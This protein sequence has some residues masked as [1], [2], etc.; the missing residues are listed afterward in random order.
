VHR[1]REEVKAYIGPTSGF[2]SYLKGRNTFRVYL[3]PDLSLS[4]I[5]VP[6]FCTLCNINKCC[7][8]IT[9]ETDK[10]IKDTVSLNLRHIRNDAPLRIDLNKDNSKRLDYHK[11]IDITLDIKKEFDN[12]IG[13]NA[14]VSHNGLV[15]ILEI[16]GIKETYYNN[17]LYNPK[18]SVIT[19]TYNTNL[20]LF[21]ETVGSVLNQSYG[22][23]E[24]C[25]I[26]DK[27]TSVELKE[28]IGGL[29]SI[30]K[31]VKVKLLKK[32]QGISGASNVGLRMSTGEYLCFLDHDDLLDV[33]AL[34]FLVGKLQGKNRPDAVY[35]DEDKI[36]E[37]GNRVEPHY[38]PDWNYYLLLT[39][40]YVCHLTLYNSKIAK[41]LG[42]L[43][44]DLD[45]SQDYDF[46]LRFSAQTKNIAHVPKILYHWRKSPDSTAVSIMNKPEARI[47]GIRALTNHLRIYNE[48]TFASA[49]IF[50][51]TYRPN[52]PLERNPSVS[53]I[54]PF[55]DKVQL[56]V[57]LLD[58]LA[59][60]DYRNYNVILV[61]N[62][63]KEK[64]TLDY[65]ESL[66]DV[67]VLKYDRPF[68][69]SAINNFAVKGSRADYFL[70]LNNDI[71][72]MDP[73]WL[74]NMVRL[75][76]QP[77][78]SAVGAKLLYVDHTIQH[79]GVVMGMLGLAG[80]GHK[81]VHDSNPGYFARPHLIQE[82]SAVTGACMLVKK[83]S[84]RRVGGFDENLPGAFNDIDLCLKI[85]NNNELILY[86]PHARLYHMESLSRGK[87]NHK[88][89]E[90]LEA[91]KYMEDKWGC[92]KYVDPYYNPNLSLLD[93]NYIEKR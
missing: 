56:L 78:V 29:P 52:F 76:E 74:S 2:V 54:I 39:N 53:I 63:S 75:A 37:L 17:F 32:N 31:R 4:R 22:N 23:L 16:K 40:M 35:S 73:D 65:L 82:V 66:K 55:R 87:D 26:D 30:D 5:E 12:K 3:V 68:N 81:G 11:Y 89:P 38:K 51:G 92:S 70:F 91:I 77:N 69:Y 25:V 48:N 18:I 93:T 88:E 44:S 80:H 64:E 58:T 79:A 60:T 50:P 67:K 28:Y 43:D 9:V 24:F 49:G 8:D 59:I 42:G 46:L 6:L 61:D 27:S 20:G 57:N 14:A 86:T 34:F 1:I 10:G 85:R 13:I 21:K 15:P 90:F 47:S 36:N 83:E 72:I 45:G 33:N 7:M 41:N 19:P 84:F 62:Q 71:E